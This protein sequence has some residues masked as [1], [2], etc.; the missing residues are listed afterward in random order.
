MFIIKIAVGPVLGPA[1]EP[2]ELGPLGL[3][4]LLLLG[5]VVLLG[6]RVE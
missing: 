1:F 2:L 6:L 4:L 5:P 3:V